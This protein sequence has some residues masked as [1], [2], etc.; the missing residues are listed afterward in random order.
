METAFQRYVAQLSRPQTPLARRAQIARSLQLQA[1]TKPAALTSSLDLPH[2]GSGSGIA[3]AIEQA[4]NIGGKV[5]LGP[6]ILASFA[7]GGPYA[8]IPALAFQL[9]ELLGVFPSFAGK[10]KLLDT[11]QAIGRL[12]QSQNPE[13]QQLAAN[14]AIYARN[15]VPLSTS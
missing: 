1:Q 14:L 2:V 12:A 3:G 15:G 10:P 6:E 9:A 5:L 11:V 7:L 13:I 4:V 8:V